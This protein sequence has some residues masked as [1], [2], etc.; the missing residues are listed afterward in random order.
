MGGAEENRIETID[1]PAFFSVVLAGIL[2]GFVAHEF[3]HIMLL[4]ELTSITIRFGG[5]GSP[6]SVCCLAQGQDALESFAY[7]V[8][9][10][11]TLLWIT[12]NNMV[13]RRAAAAE[14]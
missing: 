2:L 8:Q 5:A 1:I 11:V 13:Y 3:T 12:M 9:F 6:V 10:L 14:A 4:S 7:F